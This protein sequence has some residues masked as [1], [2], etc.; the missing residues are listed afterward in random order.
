[1]PR[2]RPKST[3]TTANKATE[4]KVLVEAFVNGPQ[5]YDTLS[6][7]DTWQTVDECTTGRVKLVAR[8]RG[9][10]MVLIDVQDDLFYFKL[11]EIAEKGVSWEGG[12]Y[13]GVVFRF[14]RL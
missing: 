8:T 11:W 4:C 9:S 10:D 7:F 13:E 14:E 6:L 12:E 1:M 2:R 3:N 5:Q